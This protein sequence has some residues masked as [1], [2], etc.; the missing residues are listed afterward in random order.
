MKLLII[1][2]AVT[3][4]SG[5]RGIQANKLINYLAA[6]YEVF[7]IT[8]RAAKESCQRELKVQSLFF[9][10]G[11]PLIIK[12]TLRRILGPVMTFDPVY[13]NSSV[14]K[15]VK[16]LNEEGIEDILTLSMD[17]SNAVIGMKLK[18]RFPARILNTY[19][20]DPVSDN[21]YLW[22]GSA[23]RRF[24]RRLEARLCQVSDTVITPS[25][26]TAETL[27]SRY[28]AD[29]CRFIN[30]PHCYDMIP[31]A[32]TEDNNGY[33]LH[34]GSLNEKRSPGP[35][36]DEM[37]RAESSLR[38]MGIKGI[39]LVGPVSK[40]LKPKLK[41]KYETYDWIKM[42][43][44]VTYDRVE[45][46]ITDAAIL[47]VI[48]APLD[49][50]QFFPSKIVEYLPFGK[51]II[52]VTPA[53]SETERILHK[54]GNL[55]VSYGD[56]ERLTEL[57]GKALSGEDRGTRFNPEEFHIS[58]VGKLWEAALKKADGTVYSD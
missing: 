26:Q 49:S 6:K 47:L 19:I 21:L 51:P 48:D 55:A 50:S 40:K 14:R 32:T 1:A 3:T 5:A 57:I 4:Q 10:A 9:A 28:G 17:L 15:A 22:S 31:K 23:G 36:L 46:Y 20:S 30:I 8:D 33:I 43:D 58:N 27:K 35:V 11:I 52:G 16:I 2:N 12:R 54:S 25:L 37:I 45:A 24:Y 53:G 56:I 38:A 13:I 18:K 29:G 44:K 41:E 34:L 42:T 7:L 39:Q